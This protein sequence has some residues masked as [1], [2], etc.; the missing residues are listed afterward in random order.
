M[1][2]CGDCKHCGQNCYEKEP[3]CIECKE[4]EN[5]K[6]NKPKFEPRRIRVDADY[7][8]GSDDKHYKID[9]PNNKY[10]G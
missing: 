1:I 7:V 3:A 5:W 6:K 10:W 9:L 4:D 8:G 2:F